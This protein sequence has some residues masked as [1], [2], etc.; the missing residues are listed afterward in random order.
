MI[1]DE[2][3]GLFKMVSSDKANFANADDIV[4]ANLK[5]HK[6]LTH[7][8]QRSVSTASERH[9]FLKKEI[10]DVKDASTQTN[11]PSLHDMQ[12]CHVKIKPLNIDKMLREAALMDQLEANSKEAEGT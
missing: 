9:L 2:F 6:Q 7:L 3:T 1:L 12:D 10:V 4:V 5:L 11:D 8:E